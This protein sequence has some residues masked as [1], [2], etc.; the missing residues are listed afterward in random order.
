MGRINENRNITEDAR[1]LIEDAASVSRGNV[2]MVS[3]QLLDRFKRIIRETNP[4][5][6]FRAESHHDDLVAD[7]EYSIDI[8]YSYVLPPSGGSTGVRIMVELL[9]LD[10][11]LRRTID[12]DHLDLFRYLG[13]VDG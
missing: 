5:L 9:N 6:R 8:D 3:D 11:P 12:V 7:C 10:R 2:R 4:A 1:E 13:L